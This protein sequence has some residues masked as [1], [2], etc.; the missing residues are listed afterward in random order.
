MRPLPALLVALLLAVATVAPVAG[1]DQPIDRSKSLDH[2]FQRIETVEN[3]TNQ[4]S[5]PDEDVRR[6][7]YNTTGIDIGTATE[8][9]AAQHYNRY[10]AYTFE[11]RFRGLDSNEQR[12]QLVTDRL[13]AI[14]AQQR[15]LER[16]QD[17]AT[18]RYAD[19]EISA[20]ALLRT[21]LVVHAEATD[22]LESLD[23]VSSAQTSVPGYT[24]DDD[25]TTRLRTIK[26]NL[27]ALT[28][29][30]GARLQSDLASTD[31][32]PIYIEAGQEA[33]MFATVTDDQYVRETRLASARDPSAPDE[34]VSEA[35]NDQNPERGQLDVADERL[36]ELY[37]W[38]YE[39]QRPSFTF[40]GTSGIYE[41]TATH[42]N[43]EL[44][45]YLDGGTTDVFYETQFRD[46]SSVRTRSVDTVRNGSLEVTVQQS[47]ATGPMLVSAVNNETGG[48]VDGR[49]TV[50]GQFVGSTGDDGLL[51]TVEPRGNYT[52]T[53]TTDTGRT[54]AIGP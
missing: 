21:R 53:V 40:Y 13:S 7:E 15:E 22:L 6:T 23:R 19:G 36:S 18:R 1:I 49:V 30:I 46:F 42:P 51:W 47:T 9:W 45:T 44:A 16:Q 8:A 33:Y 26:G 54:A 20:R 10:D 43:G 52:V 39:R 29:P 31:S 24:L 37:P 27:R 34:F 32:T 17:R 35:V 48:A 5:I 28:G 38:L 41:F 12:S 25:T 4:L 3:T 14:A 11:E 50:D 2:T